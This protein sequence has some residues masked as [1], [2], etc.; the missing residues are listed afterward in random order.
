MST[1]VSIVIVA[2]NEEATI[3]H[4]IKAAQKAAAEIGGAEIILADSASTDKTVEI[5]RSMGAAVLSLRP[6][7]ELS[8]SAGRYIGTHYAK[9]DFIL[10]IDADTLVYEGFLLQALKH[11]EENPRVAGLNGYLDDADENGRLISGIEE[12]FDTAAEIE[13]LRGGCCFYRKNAM[14]E[15]GSFNPYLTNEEEAD[16]A[17]R[18]AKNGW[19]LQML[20]IRMAVHTRCSEDLSTKI[21]FKH[22]I[23][24]L[25]NGRL[26]GLTVA[27]GYAFQNGYGLEFC[28]MRLKSTIIF[29]LWL[30]LIPLALTL[31]NQFYPKTAAFFLITI[32]LAGVWW[33]KKSLKKVFLFLMAKLFI[34]IHLI[35]G[36]PMLKFKSP[37]SYP[38]DVVY[39]DC[40]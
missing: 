34:F 10:F 27:V 15:V 14:K 9:G 11:L 31:P 17:I 1:K 40:G 12:R 21:L 16:L 30:L 13:W 6:E 29:S 26:G 36:I 24:G 22:S 19:K 20:P 33:R 37:G 25:F 35:A 39:Y 3:A 2:R 18:L 38:T 23:R 32:G 5:A 28:W 7:W 8:A 4:C